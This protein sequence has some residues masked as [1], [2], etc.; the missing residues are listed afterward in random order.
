MA[1]AAHPLQDSPDQPDRTELFDG[2]EI[3][4][5]SIEGKD[6]G[7]FLH[8]QLSNEIRNLTINS[9]V[10]VCLL[11]R[12]GRI[13]LY[14][15]LWKTEAGY[16]AIVPEQQ[17]QQFIPLLDRVLFREDVRLTD[18]SPEIT[19]LV[20]SGTRLV[21]SLHTLGAVRMDDAVF[22]S[23]S[24]IHEGIPLRIFQM[25]WLL[26][27]CVLLLC[28]KERITEIKGKLMDAGCMESGLDV[29]HS[30]RVEKG[31]PWPGYEVDETMIPYECG[32]THTASLTKGCYVGQE[33]IARIHNLGKPPRILRGLVV[34][35][36]TSP[37]RGTP[38]FH[39]KVE[40][41]KILSSGWSS[42]LKK[43]IASCSIRVKYGADGTSVSVSGVPATVKEFPLVH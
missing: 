27:P 6:A 32:L 2:L 35:G 25:D 31:S 21:E 14:F 12:E 22:Q 16:T 3:G 18:Q 5:F 36:A 19:A 7:D 41:G 9:G 30:Y 37:E 28:P 17:R 23:V 43:P 29:F 15:T 1:K 10:P 40:V 13:L 42:H 39:E 26:Q 8:R 4:L 34:E 38:V 11:N 33:I 24:F 20:L